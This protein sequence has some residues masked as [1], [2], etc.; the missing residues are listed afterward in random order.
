MDWNPPSPPKLEPPSQP[1]DLSG[2]LLYRYN[3]ADY[4]MED[5]QFQQAILHSIHDITSPDSVFNQ[6][7]G[8]T[9]KLT[10]D[11]YQSPTQ[12]KSNTCWKSD[13]N[14]LLLQVADCRGTPILMGH[15]FA[16]MRERE[17]RLR[18]TS[19]VT[20]SGATVDGPN[21]ALLEIRVVLAN[22][23]CETMQLAIRLEDAD[24]T[25]LL[26]RSTGGVVLMNPKSE[27][28]KYQ[29]TA[30]LLKK[31][32]EQTNDPAVLHQLRLAETWVRFLSDSPPRLVRMHKLEN[33]DSSY[34]VPVSEENFMQVGSYS[35]FNPGRYKTP[36]QYKNFHDGPY[37]TAMVGGGSDL[38][39]HH[40]EQAIFK[41]LYEN[42]GMIAD[43]LKNYPAAARFPIVLAIS[44]DIFTT[45]A[46]CS[47]CRAG[48]RTVLESKEH[49]FGLAIAAIKK[50]LGDKFN[51]NAVKPY[52]RVDCAFPFD[53]SPSTGSECKPGS[54]LVHAV[55]RKNA[56]GNGKG[57]GELH[58]LRYVVPVNLYDEQLLTDGTDARVKSKV[59]QIAASEM[60]AQLE[61]VNH[62]AW[63]IN[64]GA[65]MHALTLEETAVL[66][67]YLSKR[68]L[69]SGTILKQFCNGLV[70]HGV[71]QE[72]CAI[73]VHASVAARGLKES[74]RL[75]PSNIRQTLLA[76]LRSYE[77]LNKAQ[78]LPFD[79]NMVA[80]I[81]GGVLD[82]IM[83][84]KAEWKFPDKVPK[85]FT[86]AELRAAVQ[87]DVK[88]EITELMKTPSQSGAESVQAQNLALTFDVWDHYEKLAK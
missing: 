27:A 70:Q 76:F 21:N 66:A 52:L 14:G 85:G 36:E 50:E 46:A 15:S 72:L 10:C 61:D 30:E 77:S 7:G 87:G 45:R 29:Q 40:S 9:S 1:E 73:A 8:S 57:T 68:V 11:K 74:D 64:K 35:F 55:S 12:D 2:P 81:T 56:V 25:Q 54:N 65:D 78:G 22:E 75:S 32:H 5:V 28:K 37:K 63:A 88:K 44:V 6:Y 24:H 69:P 84:A 3:L 43:I 47:R 62:L 60:F 33:L 23:Q 18:Q 67:I 38:Q 31:L 13:D 41:C 49:F 4:E 82:Q 34:G 48:G 17:A 51:T 58:Y 86:A 39:F 80:A 83:G 53:N 16:E 71:P 20:E 19:G 26:F 42:A 59:E 79:D